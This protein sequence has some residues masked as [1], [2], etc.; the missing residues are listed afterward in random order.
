M[1][2][3]REEQIKIFSDYMRR[4]FENR[5]ID[6]FTKLWPEKLKNLP[7]DNFRFVIVE[8]IKS[9][10]SNGITTEAAVEDYLQYV[11]EFGID[12]GKN[13][14]TAW[15]GEILRRDDLSALEKL[16]EIKKCYVYKKGTSEKSEDT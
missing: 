1:L 11:I 12:F 10:E 6:K 2:V 13:H 14:K 9:A 3:I 15:A 4:Q 16:E 8:G 5:M 7:S